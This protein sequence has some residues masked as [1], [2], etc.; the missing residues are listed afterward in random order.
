MVNWTLIS[1]HEECRHKVKQ[2]VGGWTMHWQVGDHDADECVGQQWK[3]QHTVVVVS[4]RK[5][6]ASSPYCYMIAIEVTTVNH[7]RQ[8]NVS[9]QCVSNYQMTWSSQNIKRRKGER[10]DSLQQADYW[11]LAKSKQTVTVHNALSQ[12]RPL[13]LKKK[14]SKIVRGKCHHW[15]EW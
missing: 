1:G 3:G 13:V 6:V 7:Y 4:E 12:C 9:A 2:A 8:H 11:L 5:R 15:D 10:I 14:S